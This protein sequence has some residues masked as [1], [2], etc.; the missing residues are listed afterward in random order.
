MK[1]LY[2]R[3]GAD[4]AGTV[5][6]A[7]LV[8]DNRAV[9][10]RHGYY[11]PMRNCIGLMD[12]LAKQMQP[13]AVDVFDATGFFRNHPL[14]RV[15][16][17]ELQANYEQ[18][19]STRLFLTTEVIWGRLSHRDVIAERK[20]IAGLMRRLRDFFHHHEIHLVLHLRRADLHVESLYKQGIKA[21]N[22]RGKALL[23]EL[24]ERANPD[25]ALA[26]LRILEDVFE[27]EHIIIRPFERAQLLHGDVLLD[28]LSVLGLS[29][30]A[31]EF[32]LTVANEGLQRDLLETLARLNQTQGKQ[33]TNASLLELS[34][35][36]KT[37]Y[38]FGDTK[39]LLSRD[40]R[41]AILERFSEFYDYVSARYCPVGELFV[42][43][44]P[45]DT[46]LG[47]TLSDERF[48]LVRELIERA[49]RDGVETL[50]C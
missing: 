9:F 10:A 36:L 31:H 25:N 7:N 5:S 30:H 4:K 40:E 14:D 47:Y 38:G 39:F 45:S 32:T 17:D 11:T 41:R 37:G 13:P 46:H 16:F 27:R 20:E 34:D 29:S 24:M 44:L 22:R 12:H 35:I 23:S 42:E 2:L 15:G 49:A 1:A 21:G 19:E 18:L 33:L 6:L 3:I 43:P 8:D 48:E 26:L 28:M 50:R